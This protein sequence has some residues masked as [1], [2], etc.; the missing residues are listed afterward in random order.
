MSDINL[1][2]DIAK[3][4]KP[5]LDVLL[6]DHQDKLHSVYIVGSAL[7]RDYDPK[8]SDINSVIVL[9]KMDLKFL[10]LL[11]PLGRKYGKIGIAAPLFM[12]PAYIDNSRDVFPIEFLNIKLLH[13]TIFGEDIFGDLDI[14]RSDLR[15]QCERE[16]KVKLIG[17]RQGYISAAGNQ[18]I[19]A[20]GFADSFAGYMPLFKAIIILLGR[21]T[22][23]YN[24]EIL[25]V[26]ADITGIQ[27]DAFKQVS[28][29]KSRQTKPSIEKLNI[30][31]EDYYK[32]IEQLG[33]M[34]DALEN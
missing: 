11:A 14:D 3:R 34:I 15:H 30:V 32:V 13:H 21:E 20:R 29:L 10:E 7:T 24:Q 33:E 28:A 2:T 6:E 18:K 5:F 8:I 1:K 17:L 27:T 25:S 31:F 12:T 4:Y 16:L 26:L 22:P 9:Q 19:L 23:Q